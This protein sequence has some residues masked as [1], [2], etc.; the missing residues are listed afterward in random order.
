MVADNTTPCTNPDHRLVNKSRHHLSTS[1]TIF[2]IKE[3]GKTTAD[4]NFL[5]A[6]STKKS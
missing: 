2:N 6:C 3:N 5:A 4:F 1:E